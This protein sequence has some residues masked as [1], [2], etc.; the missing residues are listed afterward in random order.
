TRDGR[1]GFPPGGV[2]RANGSG[3]PARDERSA[4][5]TLQRI[6]TGS[7]EKSREATLLLQPPQVVEGRVT[8]ADTR[9]PVPHARLIVVGEDKKF[10]EP[11][12]QHGQVTARADA[13]G[14]VRVSA[15]PGTPLAVKAFPP[16]GTPYLSV[17]KDVAWPRGA[18]RQQIDL[19]L[20]RGVLVRGR[21]TEAG[22][23][24]A[25]AGA[26]ITFWPRRTDNPH[27]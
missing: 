25:V 13:Q 9:R 11:T 23:G 27:F 3:L 17:S 26:A 20:P 12:F 21:V 24:R 2:G 5:Q 10:G 16:E 4:R 15:F 6:E 22:S 14:R 18:A 19:A 8:Q 7:S 1:G